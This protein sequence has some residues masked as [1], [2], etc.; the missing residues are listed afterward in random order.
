MKK[1]GFF[2]FIYMSRWNWQ[3]IYLENLI[4]CFKVTKGNCANCCFKWY[5]IFCCY[6]EEGLLVPIY[7]TIEGKT[8]CL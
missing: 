5:C 7:R 6:Q 3:H 1:Y 4:C 8:N 2:L